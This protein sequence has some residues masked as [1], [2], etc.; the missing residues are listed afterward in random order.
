MD[1][2]GS[3][4][5]DTGSALRATIKIIDAEPL[6]VVDQ[7]MYRIFLSKLAGYPLLTQDVESEY[8]G[9][10]I[11][12]TKHLQRLIETMVT[13]LPPDSRLKKAFSPF[14]SSIHS[15]LLKVDELESSIRNELDE[16]ETSIWKEIPIDSS[17]IEF[18]E[19]WKRRGYPAHVLHNNP[20]LHITDIEWRWNQIQLLL[21]LGQL[22]GSFRTIL[23]TL[24]ATTGIELP[25]HLVL[26]AGRT[27]SMSVAAASDHV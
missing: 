4:V 8:P 22:R 2:P 9:A 1:D 3:K 16:I 18:L 20:R 19:R 17:R 15:F 6:P 10:V 26:R 21:A 23:E 12:G 11:N 5:V 13:S 25:A 7:E 27:K 24:C 14:L